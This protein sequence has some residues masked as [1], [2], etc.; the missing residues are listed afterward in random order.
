MQ[1]AVEV[2]KR[3]F[4]V[5]RTSAR[6]DFGEFVSKGTRSGQSLRVPEDTILLCKLNNL[7]L[8]LHSMKPE[9]FVVT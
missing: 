6:R 7:H 4:A 8:F 9:K 5:T 1:G 2:V 3:D